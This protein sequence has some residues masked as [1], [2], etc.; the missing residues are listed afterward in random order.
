MELHESLPAVFQNCDFPVFLPIIPQLAYYL[1]TYINVKDIWTSLLLCLSALT[2][3]LPLFVPYAEMTEKVMAIA[4]LAIMEEAK[5]IFL[6]V[7][8]ALQLRMVLDSA[9]NLL[10]FTKGEK[11]IV[12][13]LKATAARLKKIQN[14]EE[15]LE[16][17]CGDAI[18][19]PS[20]VHSIQAVKSVDRDDSE[21]S[22]IGSCGSVSEEDSDWDSWNDDSNKEHLAVVEVIQYF[23][24][25]IKDLKSSGKS[26]NNLICLEAA[27]NLLENWEKKILLQLVTEI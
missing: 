9:L 7:L 27:L 6:K 19:H 3:K 11:P 25:G 15:I 22:E 21:T 24:L 12:I 16:E 8:D 18:G 14:L 5:L 4:G 20:S 23:L 1:L 17:R 10:P 26:T 2:D 13:I